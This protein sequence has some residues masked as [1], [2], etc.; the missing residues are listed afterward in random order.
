MWKSVAYKEWLK[1]RWFFILSTIFGVLAVGYIFLKVQYDFKF[2]DPNNYWYVLLFMKVKYFSILK[3]V[4]LIIGFAV[5]VTQYF[6]ETVD[7]RIKL[8]FHLP[9]NENK[10]L[11][12]MMLFGTACLLASSTL[13]TLIFYV[14]STIYFPVDI[15]IPALISITPWLLSGFA[16]YYLVAFIILEPMWKY[17]LFYLVFASAIFPIFL[18]SSIAG[19]FAPVNMS[20]AVLVIGLSISLLFSGYRF[21]KGEQ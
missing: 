11:L 2:N 17:R 19:G 1:I 14:L 12:I 15:I 20:L 18:E 7:K 8:T 6:P 4:P 13:L 10:I 16:I 9:I 5:S 3:F 21:R